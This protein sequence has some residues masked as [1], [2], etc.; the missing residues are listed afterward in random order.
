MSLI[1]IGEAATK[2][3]DSA[4]EFVALHPEIPWRNIRG[5]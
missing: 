3:M 1:I 2:L 5:M 4:P